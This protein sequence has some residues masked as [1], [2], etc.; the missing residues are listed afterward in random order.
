M[1]TSV[2]ALILLPLPKEQGGLRVRVFGEKVQKSGSPGSMYHFLYPQ[3]AAPIYT[4]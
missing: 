2:L 3:R 4:P 1:D